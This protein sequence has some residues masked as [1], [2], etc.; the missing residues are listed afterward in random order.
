VEATKA[1]RTISPKLELVVLQPTPF[2]NI[3]CTYCY[4]PTRNATDR[5]SLRT[6]ERGE[7]LVL[8]I[9][10]YRD[11]F[12]V[13]E[14]MRP[15]NIALIHSF[16][17]NGTLITDEWCVFIKERGLTIGVSLDGPKWLHDINRVNR[18]G[19]GTLDQTMLGIKL[20]KEHCLYLSVIAVLS[21][22]SL[23]APE[24]LFD[25]FVAE[26]VNAVGFN[27]EEIEASNEKSSLSTVE[28]RPLYM[29]FMD[30]FW[31]LA[32]ETKKLKYVREI[33]QTFGSILR[34][35][36]IEFCNSQT[37]PF[38]ILNI[39]CSGNFSTFCPELLGLKCAKY[40]DFVFG[41][42]NDV[43]LESAFNNQ[44]FK[45]LLRDIRRG[46]DNCRRECQ[47][48]SVCGGG[49]PSNKLAENGSVESTETMFC[50]LTRKALCDLALDR[51]EAAAFTDSATDLDTH[52]PSSV[53]LVV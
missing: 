26:G 14:A 8:P 35:E 27:V 3:D 45:L 7:P 53:G 18:K 52:F 48:F 10:Y 30:R 17:T 34:P 33:E 5:L 9:S 42:I 43:E 41:N 4:L 51:I 22:A 28:M 36:S 29:D 2:C 24:E 21:R 47:Y 25:F 44:H 20:L 31:R 37:E 50:R 46:V 23:N 49:A 38:S 16:Q 12:D 13:I 11:A 6:I 1:N 39:D 15:H 19:R 40:G 32:T